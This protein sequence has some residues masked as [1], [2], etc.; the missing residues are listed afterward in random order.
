LRLVVKSTIA[1]AALAAV[2]A[3]PTQG[4]AGT[5]PEGGSLSAEAPPTLPPLPAPRWGAIALRLD[6]SVQLFGAAMSGVEVSYRFASPLGV[7][8]ALGENDMGYG[9]TGLAADLTGRLYLFNEASGGVSLAAGPWIR[10]ANEFGTVGFL[11]GEL[12][13]EYRPRGGFS[14]LLGGGIST[15]LNNSGQAQCPT[16]G[17]LD[18]FLWTDHY[19]QGDRTLYLRLAMGASF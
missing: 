12:A 8:L 17:I 2:V 1:I 3:L 5:A 10:T 16:N 6:S 18:C 13:A 14:I 11:S 19:S 4:H 9:H 15:A 7:D